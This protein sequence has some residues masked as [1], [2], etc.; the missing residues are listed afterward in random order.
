MVGIYKI[1]NNINGQCYIGQSVDIKRR[2]Q[3][4]KNYPNTNSNYPLYLAFKKYGLENFTFETLEECEIF[5][6]DEKEKYYIEYFNSYKKGYNQTQGGSGS[7]GFTVKISLDELY[8]IY[9]LLLHSSLTQKEIATLY[10]VGEDTISEINQGKTRQLE[11]YSYPLRNNQKSKNYCI[12]CGKE[13]L[14]SSTRC[15]E[16]NKIFSRLQD[17]PNREVLKEAIRKRSFLEIGRQY[18]V[19]DNSIRKWCI[20]YNL[21][22]KKT[23]I[24]KYTDEEWEKI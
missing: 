23:D 10:K 5:E 11:G 17:R 6:L 12:D 14:L 7:K 16:C 18:N 4:H 24:K 22:S 15:H 9:D 20:G 8:E 19:S 2:W 3:R 13:I 1:T 21:P